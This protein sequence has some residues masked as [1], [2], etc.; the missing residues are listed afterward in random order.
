MAIGYRALERYEEEVGL[1]EETLS[2]RERVLGPEHPDTITS[3][4]N[5]A[6]TVRDARRGPPTWFSTT[7]SSTTLH[8]KK[9]GRNALCHCGSGEKYKRCHGR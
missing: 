7:Q 4:N 1:D 5:L 9:I 3:R 2:T 8:G 6:Q